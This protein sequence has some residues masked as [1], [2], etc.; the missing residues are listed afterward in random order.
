VASTV[1]VRSTGAP[2]GIVHLLVDLQRVHESQVYLGIGHD[3]LLIVHRDPSDGAT[4]QRSDE[5]VSRL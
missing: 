1:A 5:T 3:T 2:A 4:S